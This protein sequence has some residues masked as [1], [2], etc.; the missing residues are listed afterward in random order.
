MKAPLIPVNED[1]KWKLLS[2]KGELLSEKGPP[3]SAC[4]LRI[5]N[6]YFR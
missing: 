1:F 2:E 5:K 6:A 4:K 3:K